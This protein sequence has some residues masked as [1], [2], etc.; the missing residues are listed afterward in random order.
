MHKPSPPEGVNIRD[1]LKEFVVQVDENE[2]ANDY[3]HRLKNFRRASLTYAAAELWCQP[4]IRKYLK[5][6]IRENGILTTQP[7]EKGA[8]ELDAFHASYRVK[9][10]SMRLQK[11][12]LPENGD[13]YLDILQNETLGLIEHKIEVQD[14]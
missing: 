12:Q 6:K 3:M 13:L 11:L 7:T 14:E 2:D 1:I 10:V 9:R 5:S 4:G 8:K